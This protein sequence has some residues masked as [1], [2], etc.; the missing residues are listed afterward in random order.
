MSFLTSWDSF[1][2]FS[3][4]ETM[5]NTRCC[6]LT[7]KIDSYLVHE[8]HWFYLEAWEPQ[9]D[10]FFFWEAS[11]LVDQLTFLPWKKRLKIVFRKIFTWIISLFFSSREIWYSVFSISSW[12]KS[13]FVIV[14]P[15]S[16]FD[17]RL[18]FA[19]RKFSWKIALTNLILDVW[20]QTLFDWNLS[21]SFPIW[22]SCFSRRSCSK[23][24][25]LSPLRLPLSSFLGFFKV[26]ICACN[27][28]CQIYF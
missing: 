5:L 16:S 19:R 4:S 3:R 2:T 1:S 8:G 18:W 26:I 21:L 20:I 15:D 22:R 27:L 10:Q 14:S 24:M 25:N 7:V 9:P 11:R 28:M 12:S 17:L 13:I 23:R 6:S